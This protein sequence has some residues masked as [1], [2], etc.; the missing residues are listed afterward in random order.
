M[1]GQRR[2]GT[3]YIVATPLGNLEDVT[4]RALRILREVDC[5]A[6][7]DTRTTRKLLSAYD[8]HTPLIAY[9]EQ[10]GKRRTQS[11]LQKIRD[12]R[13]IALVSE[14]G[15]PGISDPGHELIR[16][17]L[18][19]G[20]QVTAVPGPSAMIVA[21]ALSGLPTDRFVFQGFLPRK[22]AQRLRVLE[23]M[24][25]E[26][27]T[28]VLYESP[29]RLADTLD[30]IFQVWGNRRAALARELTKRF[31]ECRRE[32]VNVLRHWARSHEV[33]GEVTLV[34]AGRGEKEEDERLLHE[35]IRFLRQRC[36]LRSKDI[37]Q[38]IHEETGIPRK[39]IYQAVLQQTNEEK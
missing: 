18:T 4:L 23:E 8:L 3:L 36:R 14:A 34:I 11:I 9:H 37:V 2:T 7:E 31:E 1:E 32:D 22:R 12:R 26:V 17:C 39:A 38:V 16:A 33:K 27:R 6:A 24:R 29:R 5:I 20:H 30:D 21:L 28:L 15:M 13:D 19:E 25:D 35:R 10:G